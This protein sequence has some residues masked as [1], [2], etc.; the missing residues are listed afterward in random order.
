M[1]FGGS[2]LLPAQSEAIPL[3]NIAPNARDLEFVINIAGQGPYDGTIEYDD[4][5]IDFD[6]VTM[7]GDCNQDGVVNG[8]DLECVTSIEERDIVLDAINSLPGDFD[9]N[10]EVDFDDFLRLSANFGKTNAV[11][12]E[13]DLNDDGTI[14]FADFLLMSTNFG[15]TEE[16]QRSLRS[17]TAPEREARAIDEVFAK[18]V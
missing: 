1:S 7:P 15:R 2:R 6:D 9:G 16:G 10:G 13:G 11:R 17:L 8:D 14:N 12:E 3:G 4:G 18:L 5:V